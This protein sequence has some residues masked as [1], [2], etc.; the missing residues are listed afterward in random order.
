MGGLFET[1]TIK[2]ELKNIYNPEEV[3]DYNVYGVTHKC[4]EAKTNNIVAVKV[5][6][7]KYL[8][9][10]CGQQNLDNCL[11]IIRQEIE[12]LK[13]MNGDYSLHLIDGKE[14]I[15]SFYIITEI[16]DT[17]LDKYLL[18]KRSGLNIDEIKYLFNKLNIAFKRMEENKIIHENL[19]MKNILIKY[20]KNEIIPLL[21][22]YG[23]KGNLDEKLNIMQSTS[24]YSSPELLIGEDYD[25][26]VDLWSIGII[27]YRL[28]FN[29][30]PFNGETQAAIY[31]DI[32]KKK[33][34]IQCQDNYYFNDLLKKLLAVDPYYRMTWEEY[35]N[36]KFWESNKDNNEKKNEN[37]NNEKEKNR[38]QSFKFLYKKNK[39]SPKNKCYNI[40]YCLK[41]DNKENQPQKIEIKV[42]KNNKDQIIEYIIYDKLTNNV[43]IENLTKLILYGCNI[44]NIDILRYIQTINLLELDLSRNQIDNIE[45]LSKTTYVNLI[46]LNLNNNNIYD[47]SPLTQVYFTNLKNLYLAHNQISDITPLSQVP[48][49]DLDKLKLAS[50]K[51][52]DIE[53]L[54]K[55]PFV[56]LTYLDLKNNKISEASR[57]LAYISIQNLLYLD[58][59]HNSIKTIEGLLSYQ[60]HKLINLDLGDN[61]ISNI[62]IL[63][64][65]YFY[66][67]VRLSL[68]DNNIDNGNVFY[69]V[70]FSNL[71][72]LNL[73]YNNIENIY[74]INYVVFQDLEKLDL[75]GNKINDLA[76]LYQ[77]TLYNLKELELKNNKLKENENNEVILNYLQTKKKDLKIIYN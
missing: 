28:Y 34:F 21:S 37:E 59:S 65:V 27:L 43:P 29:E 33:N 64:E 52:R 9:R 13:K 47:I 53:T 11:D 46:T 72:E 54:T 58:L 75:N 6:D 41:D 77:L 45:P 8:E 12:A 76:P 5:I 71:K 2:G 7:K 48:F 42:D 23:K 36:H 63:K 67:L 70:P 10:I 38:R 60:Y 18:D 61:N 51:I 32:K 22:D 3:L 69:E 20:D 39:N 40:Y 16:W 44:N 17:N 68:F 62:D 1:S 50:N 31:N 55:V 66:N 4:K 15:E 57:A 49:N 24:Q 25:Y 26:K 14:T 30:F 35:F 73:S 74:F 56:N 19:N